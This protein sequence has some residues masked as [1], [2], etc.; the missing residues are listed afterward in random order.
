MTD[1]LNTVFASPIGDQ[2]L[3]YRR[4]YFADWF[5]L[6]NLTTMI[7]S[8]QRHNN[9]HSITSST[10]LSTETNQSAKYWSPIGDANIDH[11]RG[12]L[13]TNRKAHNT[14]FNPPITKEVL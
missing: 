7:L 13:E 4:Q 6:T 3:I 5:Q 9:Y 12:A 10:N 11:K 2:Y 8:I 14:V 1:R